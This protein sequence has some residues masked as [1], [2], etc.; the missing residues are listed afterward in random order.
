MRIG[1]A[2]GSGAARGLAHIPYIEAMDELGLKP[3]V[4]A[5]SSIGA[6][7]GSGWA[8]GMTG[9]ELREHAYGVLGSLQQI[10]STLWNR[11]RFSFKQMVEDGLSMQ[12][13]SMGITKAFLPDGFPD[14]F[15]EL[16]IPFHAVATDFYAWK[17]T[18]FSSGPLRPAI[19]A[20][21]AIPSLFRPVNVEGRYYIDGG[22]TDPLPLGLIAGRCDVLIGVDVHRTPELLD[23]SREPSIT[24]SA[25][26]ATEIMSQKL[27]DATVLQYPP[28][29]YV[30]AE[31]GPFG[32]SEFWRVREIVDNATGDKDRFKR[33]V[34]DALLAYSIRK[35]NRH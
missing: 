8:N 35:A 11:N 33:A 10:A 4:I 31:V 12:V 32:G 26:V 28:D 29:V 16:K 30:R 20:S 9:A 34:S 7:I 22:V 2:L 17:E 5:G 23:A 14:D 1:V 27:V 3:S 6:L 25:V 24:D 18:V 13:N 21:L 19:A 15:A